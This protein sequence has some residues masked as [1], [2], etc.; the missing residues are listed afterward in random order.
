MS[1]LSPVQ[2]ATASSGRVHALVGKVLGK[3]RS[4]L[5]GQSARD[6]AQRNAIIAFAVR[7]ASA[8]LLYL[9]QIV[10]ARFMGT[11]EYGVFVF[12]WTWVLVLGG[13]SHLG[14]G[15]TMMRLLP[16]YHV[17]GRLD[18]ARGLVKAG[19]RVAVVVGATFAALAILTLSLLG[20]RIQ[21]HAVLPLF[22]VLFCIPGFALTD[23]Q[24]GIGR[25]R[26][27]MGVALAPPYILRPLLLL[28]AMV[29]AY[30]LGLPMD[31]RTAAGAAIISTYGTA[32]LQTL[33]IN[34]QLA[35]DVAP[36]P[37][38]YAPRAWANTALPLLVVYAAELV[39][40][41][42]DVIIVSAFLTPVETGKYFAAAKT[43]AL[44]L[45]VHYAVGSA[46]ANRFS[47]LHAKGD[48][49][50][51]EAFVAD[52]VRW[53]FW[54]SLAA[55]LGILAL[56][57]PLLWLFS[58]TYVD[59]YPVMVILVLGFLVRASMGPAEFLLSMLGEQR[60][61][62]MIQVA[63]AAVSTLLCLLLVPR[64]GLI[65]AAIAT[66]SALSFAAVANGIVAHRRLGLSI[67]IFALRGKR[68]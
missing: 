51:L 5:G 45:F 32:F 44:V 29:A 59:A 8:G 62:A 64:L 7:V 47:A 36:G 1:L 58:P 9:S 37:S 15:V 16:A 10:L 33:L 52:A 24:D 18:L 40:Q 65:G 53:T 13:L 41:N 38:A 35:K 67:S 30:G 42:I 46:V 55:A 61:S 68:R 12:V 26:G 6:T 57:R 19:R 56:G 27:W 17:G 21:N 3:L 28:L 4:L 11:F 31:A 25:A 66:A 60:A 14:L 50:E 34:R 63:T 2:D 54:P 48:R 39:I 43:M 22:L 49:A 23:L 20:D